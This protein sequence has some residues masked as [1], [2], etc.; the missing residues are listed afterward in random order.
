M[1]TLSRRVVSFG[2]ASGYARCVLGG[3]AL[4]ADRRIFVPNPNGRPAENLIGR[5]FGKLTVVSKE[6]SSEGG[7]RWGCACECGVRKTV[8][9]TRLVTGTVRSCGCDR[10]RAVKVSRAQPKRIPRVDGRLP[11]EYFTW[12]GMIERCNNPRIVSFHRYGGRG[13]RVCNR[14][15]SSF[16]A[17]IAD[18]GPKPGPT[19][20]I[21]R[22]NNDGDY[23]PSNVRWATR[24]E[25]SENTRRNLYV[26]YEG[27]RYTV[28]ALARLVDVGDES[29]RKRVLKGHAITPSVVAEMRR[30]RSFQPGH[31]SAEAPS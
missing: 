5:V 2:G 23:E 6:P 22:I 31:A 17:F 19:Y 13:I 29:L 10:R 24:R 1:T 14:W 4:V 30:N 15:L 8:R 26:E 27:V 3:L 7:T 9:R 12:R 28:S 18:V 20:S 16:D 21:D 11:P 25:Q